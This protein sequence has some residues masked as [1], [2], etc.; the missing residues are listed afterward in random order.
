[1]LV[2][3]GVTLE[4]RKILL[5][6]A[7]G[8]RESYESWLSSGRDMIARGLR[9]PALVI[10]DG[11]PGSGRPCGE[12]WPD[13][14]EQRCTVHALRN[15][16]SKLPEGHHQEVK[17]RWWKAFDEAHSPGEATRQLQGIIVDYRSAYPSAMAVV[18]ADLNAL[19]AHLRFPSEHRKR[20][21]T[22]NL[23]ERRSWR[24]AGA[25]RSSAGFPVKPPRCHSSG[26]CLSSHHA[27]GAA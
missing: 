5:G 23:L 7:L 6:L 12:L 2:C 27:A 19:V 1:V 9:A 24:S 10:A 17:A 25:P 26:P 18:E 15:V 11:R 14:L 13:A 8:S 22:T 3:W 16:T 4:G 21:R 20:I